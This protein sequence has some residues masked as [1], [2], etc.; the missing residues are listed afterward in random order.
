MDASNAQAD[1]FLTNLNSS[2]IRE[3][4]LMGS[5]AVD[6]NWI[7]CFPREKIFFTL[8]L[9]YDQIERPSI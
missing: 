6:D 4:F 3:S 5:E 1:V 2:V 7:D 8:L 9:F